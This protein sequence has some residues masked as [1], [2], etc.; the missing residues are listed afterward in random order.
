MATHVTNQPSRDKEKAYDPAVDGEGVLHAMTA[1]L[2]DPDSQK[3][4]GVIQ[5]R[6]RLWHRQGRQSQ[7]AYVL[8]CGTVSCLVAVWSTLDVFP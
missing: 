4:I 7:V 3:L 5:M 1:P 8:P 6:N 2:L